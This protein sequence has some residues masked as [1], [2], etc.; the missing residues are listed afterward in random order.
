VGNKYVGLGSSEADRVEK[1]AELEHTARHDKKRRVDVP[2]TS[3]NQQ[4][5]ATANRAMQTAVEAVGRALDTIYCPGRVES[6]A[7]RVALVCW[8]M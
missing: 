1:A 7:N 6:K 8:L 2:A 5:D 4:G 3:L